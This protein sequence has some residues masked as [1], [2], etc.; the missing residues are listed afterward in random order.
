MLY[1]KKRMQVKNEVEKRPVKGKQDKKK[2]RPWK[3]HTS[4]HTHDKATSRMRW[5]HNA[6]D[7]DVETLGTVGIMHA[8]DTY[9]CNRGVGCETLEN[10]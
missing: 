9:Q 4:H 1:G 10:R 8:M 6:R 7:R 5:L 3:N 2:V